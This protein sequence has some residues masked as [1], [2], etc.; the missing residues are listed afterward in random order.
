[1][2]LPPGHWWIDYWTGESYA[3]GQEVTVPAPLEHLPLLVRAG[4]IIPMRDYAPSVL[5]GNNATLTLDVYPEGATE[6]SQ[7]TLY[8]DDGTSN[9]YLTTGYA[10]TQITC[11]PGPESVKF[12][13]AAIQGDYRG[14][15]KQRQWKLEMHLSS[16]PGAVSLNGKPVAWN[17]DPHKRVLHLDWRAA[18]TDASEIIV[19]RGGGRR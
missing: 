16:K 4:A 14:R 1:M 11:Q 6:A 13:I 7:F 12:Q 9:D 15:L 10:A 18:T 2:W 8:E 3:G 5:R 17:Y 19:S